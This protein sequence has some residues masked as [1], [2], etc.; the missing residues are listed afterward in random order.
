MLDSRAIVDKNHRY[1]TVCYDTHQLN[2]IVKSL[3]S[4]MSCSTDR[5][6]HLSQPNGWRVPYT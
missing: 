4:I 3:L 5:F 2:G 6:S 1:N